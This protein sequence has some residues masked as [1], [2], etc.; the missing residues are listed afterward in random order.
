MNYF[1]IRD[2]SCFRNKTYTQRL[3]NYLILNGF[4]FNNDFRKAELIIVDTCGYI[5]PKQEESVKA[6]QYLLEHKNSQAKIIVIGCLPLIDAAGIMNLGNLHAI[7]SKELEKFDDLI[8][9]KIKFNS[10]EIPVKI[11]YPSSFQ[12]TFITKLLNKFES[13][14]SSIRALPVN[15]LF[16]RGIKLISE[17]LTKTKNN[18]NSSDSGVTVYHVKVAT[19]CFGNCAYC[20]IKF[21]LGKMKSRPLKDIVRDFK[22][23]ININN[24]AR[25]IFLEAHDLGGYGLDTNSTVVELLTELFKVEG[26]YKVILHDINV[27]WLIKYYADLESIFIKNRN[28]IRYIDIAIQSGSNRVLASMK[29]PYLIEDAKKAVVNLKKKLPDVPVWTDIIVGFPGETEGDFEKSKKF[30][31]E[32]ASYGGGVWLSPY[33]DRPNTES[34]KMENKIDQSTI[35]MRIKEILDSIAP[36]VQD[37]NGVVYAA[38]FEG[39]SK[40][41]Q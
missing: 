39:G 31:I 14:R 5:K 6:I 7:A 17:K 29:R 19:G 41:H 20:A 11:D 12:D 34:S 37:S 32:F 16:I 8:S 30:I 24:K 28:R 15:I 21:A 33:S 9:A 10:V 1:Y 36:Y 3:Y 4:S 38:N 2:L 23:C 25:N 22:A 13:V 27:L 35:S 18:R 40:I 26:N